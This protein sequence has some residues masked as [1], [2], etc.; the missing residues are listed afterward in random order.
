MAQFDLH[1]DGSC[2][3][4]GTPE[5]EGG[6]AFAVTLP[7][8]TEVWNGIEFFGKIREGNQNNNRAEL[9]G[10]LRALIWLQEHIQPD[11][12]YTIWCD[13]ELTVDGISGKIGRNANRDLWDPIERICKS[14]RGKI[15]IQHIGSH[16]TESSDPRHIMNNHVDRLARQAA[17]SLVLAPVEA[18]V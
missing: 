11:D 10:V 9:E 7:S 15:S 6:W 2:I 5:A 1:T 4:N 18:Y 8:S 16:E 17:R 3:K 13:S 14:L 12:H